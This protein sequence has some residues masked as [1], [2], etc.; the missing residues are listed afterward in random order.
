M[1]YLLRHGEIEVGEPKRFIG[2]ID[3]PLTKVGIEQAYRWRQQWSDITFAEIWC[4]DLER[5]RKTAEIMEDRFQCPMRITKELREI[6]LGEWDGLTVDFIKS[7]FSEKWDARGR[8]MATYRPPGGE[9]FADLSARVVPFIEEVA[10]KAEGN[11][12]IT[13]HSG[14]NRVLLCHVLGMPLVNLF[15]LAQDFSALNLIEYTADSHVVKLINGRPD[16][17]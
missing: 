3:L 14:V 17:T 8:D 5:S 10:R 4:S 16:V 6:D 9:S 1:I 7:R 12:L 13:T 2:Q 15:R 11:I